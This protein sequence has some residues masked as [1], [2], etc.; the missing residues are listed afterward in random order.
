M[1]AL[2]A[3]VE[4][5][6]VPRGIDLAAVV[7]G[8]LAGAGRA[9][10]EQF[11]MFGVLPLALVMGLGGGIIRD[12]LLGLRPVALTDRAYLPTVV[13]AASVGLVFARLLHRFSRAFRILDALA[14]GLFTLVGV[15]RRCCTPSPTPRRPSS[16]CARRWAA[17]SSSM[18]C[19]GGRPRWSDRAVDR[20]G[21]ARWRLRVRARDGARRHVPDQ[22]G[23]VFR[24][25]GLHAFG[26]RGLG[27]E[28]P[29]AAL[30]RVEPRM[31]PISDAATAPRRPRQ[32]RAACSP[33][34]G[35]YTAPPL[36]PQIDSTPAPGG[37]LH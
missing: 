34:R 22:R 28:E 19:Q 2:T 9:V 25:R 5:R 15:E 10:R 33:L 32:G 14:L 26:G 31:P 8:A 36:A 3:V 20:D 12:V 21:G 4:P 29:S 6:Q 37:R 11:D 13:V 27:R 16:A 18:R 7:V 24:S 23:G 30:R 35:R 17:G 1:G